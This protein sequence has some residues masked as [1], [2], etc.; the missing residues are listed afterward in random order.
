[1]RF[2]PKIVFAASILAAPAAFALPVNLITNGSFEI[3]APTDP[4]TGLINGATYAN[5][6]T[7]GASWDVFNALP[8]W[9]SGANDAGIE[10]QTA[11]TGVPV[12]PY[13]GKYHVEL[14]SDNDYKG[15][16]GPGFSNSSMSQTIA[17]LGSGSYI[18]S[19]AYSPRTN[20]DT[21][22][23]I[24]FTFDSALGNL[25]SGSVTSVLT[26]GGAVTGS[27][28]TPTPTAIGTWSIATVF[29]DV[30]VGGDY[31][32]TFSAGG[33]DN[34]LGGFIDDVRLSAVP[35]PAPALLLLGAVASFG[36]LRRFRK[37]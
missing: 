2:I 29:F 9:T 20:P 7:S 33:K 27:F 18:F 12:D 36:M 11:R 28:L 15:G 32:L 24:D 26:V 8:G 10:V 3:T 16:G 23:Q 14:D 5:M 37:A 25:F 30:L 13:D 17:G 34:E 22:S 4:A 19:F 35:L 1:L 31:T 6:P 21:D